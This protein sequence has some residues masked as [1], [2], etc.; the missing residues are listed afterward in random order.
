MGV[1]QVVISSTFLGR[2]QPFN[3]FLWVDESLIDETFLTNL[4]SYYETNLSDSK[5]VS[6]TVRD[7]FV[8][9]SEYPKPADDDETRS[10]LF[11]T[12]QVSDT[13]SFEHF[14]LFKLQG[15]SDHPTLNGADTDVKNNVDSWL[16]LYWMLAGSLI[17]YSYVAR[18]KPMH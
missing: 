12:G 15:V 1:K 10:P 18:I 3:S 6:I 11:V 13:A 17:S 5:V 8:S 7:E 14:A 4:K 2:P 16:K 9:A